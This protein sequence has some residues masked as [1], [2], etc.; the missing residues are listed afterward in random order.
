LRL[1]SQQQDAAHEV[2]N[3][4]SLMKLLTSD[5]GRACLS[6]DQ[7]TTRLQALQKKRDESENGRGLRMEQPELGHW[8]KLMEFAS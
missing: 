7:R 3:L 4:R 2:E 6:D 5:K 1:E 8:I